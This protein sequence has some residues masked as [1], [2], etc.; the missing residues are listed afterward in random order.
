MKNRMRLMQIEW[1][2]QPKFTLGACRPPG[3]P[4]TWPP[5]SA[6]PAW[7]VVFRVKGTSK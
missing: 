6:G 7:M 1:E 4:H 5:K 2:K 3:V